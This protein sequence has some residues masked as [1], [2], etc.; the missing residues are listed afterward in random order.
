[1]LSAREKVRLTVLEAGG[2][3]DLVDETALGKSVFV[4]VSL[5]E[6]D[7]EELCKAAFPR[8]VEPFLL[9]HV[10]QLVDVAGVLGSFGLEDKVGG[11]GR[12]GGV[13]EA[14]E[15]GEVSIS[16]GA[17]KAEAVDWFACAV[18][19]AKRRGLDSCSSR[20][21][22]LELVRAGRDLH[23]CF[24]PLIQRCGTQRRIW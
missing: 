11:V 24:L 15:V 19:A 23:W 6:L 1:M 13:Q 8:E 20:R 7:T 14:G 22:G 21:R 9:Q 12:Q 5:L 18:R 17:V 4:L 3:D 2:R 16:L 10:D